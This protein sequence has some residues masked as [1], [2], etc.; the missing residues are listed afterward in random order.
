MDPDTT[1]TSTPP[2]S[3]DQFI[4]SLNDPGGANSMISARRFAVA[5]Q[6]DMPTLAQLAGVDHNAVRS[7]RMQRFLQDAIKVI[8]A[9]ADVSGDVQRAL[10]WYRNEPLSTFDDKTAEQLVSDGRA[11]DLLRYIFALREGAAG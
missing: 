5:L 6:I 3:L 10:S 1:H 4:S 9:A 8:Q 7:E 11:D 2:S